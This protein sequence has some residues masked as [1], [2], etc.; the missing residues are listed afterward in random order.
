[1]RVALVNTLFRPHLVG[2]AERSVDE[3]ATGL[4]ARG[5]EVVVLTLT[6]SAQHSRVDDPAG[7]VVHRIPLHDDWPFDAHAAGRSALERLGWHAR[8]ARRR[9]ETAAVAQVV[10]DLRPDVLHTHNIAGFGTAV[11]ASAAGAPV[12]HTVRDY[13]L[14]CVRTT[15]YREGRGACTTTCADCLALTVPRRHPRTWPDLVVGVT[16]AV[17]DA[18]RGLLPRTQRTAVIGNAPAPVVVRRRTVDRL[19]TVGFVGRL[20]RAKGL[21]LLLDAAAA[22]GLQVVVAGS[23][24][25][26]EEAALRERAAREPWLTVLGHVPAAQLLDRVDVLAVPTQWAEPFGR[27]AAEARSAGMPVLA[28]RVGGLPEVLSGHLAAR[29]VDRHDDV[30]AWAAALRDWR[31]A[32]QPVEVGEGVAPARDVIGE[33]EALYAELTVGRRSS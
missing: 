30:T 29:F 22:A 5:H 4:A 24:T 15:R 16:H 10:R 2:G 26:S 3:L 25:P 32:W 28:A 8:E 11:W 31:D 14:L 17:L 23:G 33:H 6:P 9:R 7:F 20:E 27:V 18:H 21:P 1:M 12:V 19:R 13:Y